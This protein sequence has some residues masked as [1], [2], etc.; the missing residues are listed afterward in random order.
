MKPFSSR[1][2]TLED[3][4]EL[5]QL[6]EQSIRVLVG[7]YLDDAHVEA[8]FEIMGV[9]TVLIEDGTYFVV[10]DDGRIAGCGGWS[11]RATL[12][13]GDHSVVAMRASSTPG[14]TRLESAPCTPTRTSAD[15]ASAASYCPCARRRRRRRAFVHSNWWPPSRRAALSGLRFLCHRADR[16]SHSKGVT[17]P[18]ARMTKSMAGTPTSAGRG[19]I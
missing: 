8:S 13:G 6:M 10:E 17:V 5:R 11:R 3:L 19:V 2:A 4:P 7:A 1:P 15:G 18:C 9:D 14:L 16:G 12:F